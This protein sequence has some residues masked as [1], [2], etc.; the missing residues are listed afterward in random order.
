MASFK[1][2]RLEEDI[3]RELTAIFRELKDPRISSMLS[4]VK[5]DLSR[6]LSHCKVYVSSFY[7][8][9]DTK[10][11]VEG[12]QSA[13]GFIKRELFARLKMR[14]C[15]DLKF[16]ADDSI[17]RSSQIN[18]VIRKVVPLTINHDD[19]EETEED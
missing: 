1:S 11:S 19:E 4:I 7:G 17:E 3:N 6:D 8:M 14:K 16:I 18:E 13:S 5:C 15:P 2:N 9:D 12:L 10:K